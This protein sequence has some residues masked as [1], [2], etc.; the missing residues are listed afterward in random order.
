MRVLLA[1]WVGLA[2]ASLLVLELDAR[3]A[4]GALRARLCRRRPW[5][6]V[7]VAVGGSS[8]AARRL[9]AEPPSDLLPLEL[10]QQLAE[11]AN[12]FEADRA[13]AIEADGA[14]EV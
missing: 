3:H 6:D 5:R 4:F 14:L 7:G 8:R 2:L 1:M 13:N 11:Q 12:A 10:M 9:L